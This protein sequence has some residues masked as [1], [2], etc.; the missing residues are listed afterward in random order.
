MTSENLTIEHL[1][2]WALSGAHWHL[3]EITNHHGVVQFCEC[4]GQPVERLQ[5]EDPQVIAYLRTARSD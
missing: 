4:T 1:E 2:R 5:S 3:V